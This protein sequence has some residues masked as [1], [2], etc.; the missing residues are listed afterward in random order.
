[1]NIYKEFGLREVINANGKMTVLGASAVSDRVAGTVKDALQNYVVIDELMDYAGKVIA[2]KTGAEDGCP[3]LGA[4][5]GIAI[6]VAAS[7]AGDNLERIERIPDTEGLRNEIVIQKG[8]VVNFGG[9]IAQMIRLGG[10]KVVEAGCANKVEKEHI[11]QLITEKT[12]ALFYVKSHHAVQKGM[13]SI[14]TMIEIAKMYGI[15]LIIDGAAEEDMGKYIR[16]GADLVIYSGGKA[17][18]GPT[19]GFICGK[20][21]LIHACK[22]QYKG[23]GRA[24]KVS[25]EAMSGLISALNQYELLDAS[26]EEQRE[27]ME[28]VC[29]LL[30]AVHGLSCRVT[31]DEAGRA[32]YR[33][34]IKVDEEKTGISAADLSARLIQGDPAIYLREHFKNQ[35]LLYVDPRPLAFGQEQIVVE[36]IKVILGGKY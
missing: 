33:A 4:A 12:A 1:M 3:T 11:E 15:P 27:R 2:G 19:S 14:V 9:N 13:Q 26:G 25:K 34:E 31:Q 23:I 18:E 17:L 29:M 20:K 30:N 8:H 36:N 24:M 10:G 7:I 32:I 21:E 35:G 22:K 6:S 5:A 16:M 28:Q